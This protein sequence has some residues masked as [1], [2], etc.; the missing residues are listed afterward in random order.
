AF[1]DE[2]QVLMALDCAARVAITTRSAR[3]P[4]ALTALRVDIDDPGRFETADGNLNIPS[5]SEMTAYVM[6]TSGSTG[7]PKGVMVPH[8][9]IGRL[10]LNCGYADFKASDRVAFAANPAFDAATI[11][12]WAPL[13]NGGRIVVTDQNCLLDPSMFAE[14]LKR[15][16]VSVLWLTA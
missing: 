13:L 15:H 4:E 2:R 5:S 11:E 16:E 3:L 8:R 6:Y 7:K 12:V 9:A 1:P 10:V 14:A